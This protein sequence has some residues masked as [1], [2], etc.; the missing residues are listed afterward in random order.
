[1]L[2]HNIK[3]KDV[4]RFVVNMTTHILSIR[5]KRL[6]WHCLTACRSPTVLCDELVPR[7]IEAIY[8]SKMF[9]LGN[10]EYDRGY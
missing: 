6:R 4:V 7:Q 9:C 1:M 10:A 3:K 2:V 5:V 8:V